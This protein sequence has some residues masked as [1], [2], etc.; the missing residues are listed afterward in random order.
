MM[1]FDGVELYGSLVEKAATLAFSLIKNHPFIDGN[2]RIG[3]ASMETFLILN[4]YSIHAGVDDQERVI[5]GVASGT[6][7]RESL[8]SWLN[9]NV[10]P[11][12]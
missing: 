12:E 7:S 4:C 1:T 9:Q 11:V 2:K 5:M 6:I 8:A 3:H 10:F